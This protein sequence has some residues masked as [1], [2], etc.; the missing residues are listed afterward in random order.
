MSVFVFGESDDTSRHVAF[1]LVA[2][3]EISGRRSTVEEWGTQPLGASENDV[4]IPFA[5]RY[6]QYQCH[7][8]CR[9]G[10]L[11]T[12]FVCL[13]GKFT[14]VFDVSAVVGVLDDTAE[15]IRCEVQLLVLAHL[16]LDALRQGTCADDR[17]SLWKNLFVH[18]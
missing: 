17:Q 10:Y 5:G 14:V 6:Q 2:G 1:V 15:N 7:D 9:Y 3:S 4:G 16:Y 13:T 12:G 18:K 8:V 11:A